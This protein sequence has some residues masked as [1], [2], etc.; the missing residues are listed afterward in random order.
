[1]LANGWVQRIKAETEAKTNY[2]I[3]KL[4]GV[5]ASSVKQMETGRTKTLSDDVCL[6]VAGLLDIDPMEVIAD[7]AFE[8]AKSDETRAFWRGKMA[9]CLLLE[10][11]FLAVFLAAAGGVWLLLKSLIWF[12][13]PKQEAVTHTLLNVQ[14]YILC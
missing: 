11:R 6:K 3:A 13:T 4:L 12:L 10:W 14:Q 5:E 2:R 7:Q 9:G 1:M 8:R